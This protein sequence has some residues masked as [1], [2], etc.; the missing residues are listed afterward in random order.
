MFLEG[1]SKAAC[2]K[3]HP[4]NLEQRCRGK[5]VCC[6]QA[7]EVGEARRGSELSRGGGEEL[8]DCDCAGVHSVLIAACSL[9]E[10]AAW[11]KKLQSAANSAH[12]AALA[13]RRHE[14]TPLLMASESCFDAGV[15]GERLL[16]TASRQVLEPQQVRAVRTLRSLA[17][18]V[19]YTGP[20]PG[21]RSRLSWM[22]H[23]G[24][25]NLQSAV[26]FIQSAFAAQRRARWWWRGCARRAASRAAS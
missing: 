20:S 14:A 3:L 2:W 11:R 12:A 24:A 18:E 4:A 1:F 25:I 7:T 22:R 13:A 6:A 8:A 19:V 10:H 9:A 15:P 17:L 23:S 16:A 26:C 21:G 5:R